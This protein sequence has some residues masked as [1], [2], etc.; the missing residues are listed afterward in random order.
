MLLFA[1]LVF[2]TFSDPTIH[3]IFEDSLLESLVKSGADAVPSYPYGLEEERHSKQWLH[4]T[5]RQPGASFVLLTHLSEAQ[6]QVYNADPHGLILGGGTY[7]DGIEGYHSYMVVV[8]FEQGYTKTKT[9][10]YIT[11]TLFNYQFDKPIWSST[12]KSVNLDRYL[13]ADDE[14]L[15][16]LLIKDLKGH[17]LLKS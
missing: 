8:T 2:S 14:K 16:D 4:H 13:R 12:S 7:G 11:A 3:K 5:M 6:K 1:I 9:E 15:G 10:D 17:H